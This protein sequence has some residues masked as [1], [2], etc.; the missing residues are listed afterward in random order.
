MDNASLI[1]LCV[2][3]AVFVLMAM[4]E[5]WYPARQAVL[6]RKVRWQGN[7]AMVVLG[8]LAA[9][10]VLPATLVGVAWWAQQH[11]LG[12]FNQFPAHPAIVIAVSMLLL[13]M[14]IYWQHR[15]FHKVPVLWRVHQVHHADS[16]VDSTTGLR[17]HPLEIVISLFI[18]GSVI[19]ALGA[20]AMAVIAFEVA[21]NAFSVFNHTNI[22]LPQKL[23]DRLGYFIITQRLHRIHHSQH[24]RETN[25]NF[26]FSVTWWDRLFGS[27]TPRAAQSDETLDI[28][29]RDFPAEK[30]NA[31]VVAL[32]LMPFKHRNRDQ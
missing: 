8:A 12:L 26:G 16:L 27:F 31:G 20:P 19:I 9:R 25:S 23:D 2:F 10:L 21:L 3:L 11:N 29:Q 30:S 13:D 5:A 18:K 17:F 15:L 28:G 1:R 7:L 32:L 14:A 4:A 24:Q 22:R 6:S